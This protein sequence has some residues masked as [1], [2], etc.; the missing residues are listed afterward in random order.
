[1]QID[2]SG[3]AKKDRIDT[4]ALR[5]LFISGLQDAQVIGKLRV[6]AANEKGKVQ[7]GV[8]NSAPAQNDRKTLDSGE[9]GPLTRESFADESG[10]R[11]SKIAFADES[12]AIGSKIPA[13]HRKGTPSAD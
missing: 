7:P 10:K 13:S 6:T 1:M 9:T 12:D 11:D 2:K 4:E 5:D 8:K 3:V